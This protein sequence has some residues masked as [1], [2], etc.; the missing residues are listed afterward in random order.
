MHAAR[1]ALHR[2]LQPWATGGLYLDFLSGSYHPP[3]DLRRAYLPEDFARLQ[4]LKTRWDPDNVFRVNLDIPP[5][6]RA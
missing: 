6:G 1:A 4:E 5:L 3:E 2:R